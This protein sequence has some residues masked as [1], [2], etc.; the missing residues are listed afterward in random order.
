MYPDRYNQYTTGYNKY[1]EIRCSPGEKNIY[2][3]EYLN[4]NKKKPKKGMKH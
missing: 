4:K 1:S 2:V 3:T